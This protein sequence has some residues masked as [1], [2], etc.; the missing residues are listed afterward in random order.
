M[1]NWKA[2]VVVLIVVAA[3]IGALF[4]IPE[5]DTPNPGVDPEAGRDRLRPSGE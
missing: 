1:K 5:R 4:L 2:W 3:G